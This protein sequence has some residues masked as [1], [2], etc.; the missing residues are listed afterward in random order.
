MKKTLQNILDKHPN[1]VSEVDDESA[2]GDGY[3]VYLKPGWICS[4]SETHCVHEWNM[5]DLL[6]AFRDVAPCD[7]E[8]CRKDTYVVPE[9]QRCR[10]EDM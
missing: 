4:S 10:L 2:S 3:W 1:K 7:C 6:S 8:D 9:H 5:R